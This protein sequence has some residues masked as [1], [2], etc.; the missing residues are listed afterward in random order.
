MDDQTT[1]ENQASILLNLE[2]LIKSHLAQLDLLDSELDKNKSL[3]DSIFAN[4]P[5]YQEHEQN[6]KE[7]SKIK[8]ATKQQILKQPQAADLSNKVKSLKSQISELNGALS[9]YLREFQRLSGLNEIEGNDGELRQI[10]YV[11]RLVKKGSKNS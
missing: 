10:V 11:A 8:S 6:A 9:D 3:L 4:D 5:T 1:I 2:D 7:A